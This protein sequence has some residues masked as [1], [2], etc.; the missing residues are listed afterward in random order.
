MKNY[1]LSL[2]VHT[3][4][5]LFINS[6]GKDE[7]EKLDARCAV[8]Q[9]A[10][11]ADLSFCMDLENVTEEAAKEVCDSVEVDE[12]ITA[13]PGVYSEGLCI[14]ETGAQGCQKS[15]DSVVITSWLI[16]SGWP[17]DISADQTVCDGDGVW[18]TKS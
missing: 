4:L 10:G 12:G 14:V 16:G 3:L 15:K 2:I 18:I 5:L 1:L 9:S 11:S 17:D 7:D 13:S 6:C 8:S